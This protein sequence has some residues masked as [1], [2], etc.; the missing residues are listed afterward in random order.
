MK[1]LI[2]FL[3]LKVTFSNISAKLR[4]LF[5]GLKRLHSHE[6]H[7]SLLQDVYILLFLSVILMDYHKLEMFIVTV[8]SGLRQN[9]MNTR[10]DR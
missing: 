9:A 5:H 8:F 10:S 6:E 2:V 1:L 4:V 3:R 7:D